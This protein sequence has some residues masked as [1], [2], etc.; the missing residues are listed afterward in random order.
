VNPLTPAL[1][2]AAGTLLLHMWTNG[3]YGYFRDELYFL[4]CGEH[5]AWGYADM[6]PMVALVAHLS[7]AMFG[8]S[9]HAIRFFP[10]VAGAG[11][12]ILT[13]LITRELGGRR[14]AVILACLC[15][16]VAPV[17]LAMDDYLS[18]N[19][20]EPLFWMGGI[21]AMIK[22]IKLDDEKKWI[23]FGVFAG[24]GLMNKHSTAFFGLAVLIAVIL[25]PERRF[26]KN[27]WIWI[28]G[29]IAFLIFLPNLLW[30]IKHHWATLELLRNVQKSGKDVVLSPLAFVGQQ[31][32]IMH[33]LTAPV[34]IAGLYFFLFDREG[35]RFRVLGVTFVVFFALMMLMH[36]KNYYLAPI[37]PMMM[38]GGAV[39]WERWLSSRGFGWA[40][41]VYPALL[42]LGGIVAAPLV[43]PVLS[44]PA[45]LQYEAKL[46]ISTPKTEVA[47][48]GLL[49][50]HFGDRFGWPEMV[51]KVA[52]IYNSLPADERAKTAIFANNYGEAGAI[53]FFGPKYGLPKA[54]SGHQNYWFWGP[55][56]YTGEIAIILQ[57]D[58]ESLEQKYRSVEEVGV[59][60]HPYAMMEERQP[61][62]LCRGRKI[63]FQDDWPKLK[64]W[65]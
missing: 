46:G 15:I 43:L 10:A 33:P 16:L 30:Q 20:F 9:L 32:F 57:G 42:L 12:M 1:F 41:V 61:I 52:K 59:T 51:E 54:I 58:R 56:E 14:F 21:Y 6:A 11:V 64:H 50:Q 40:K 13:G 53:D 22:A 48:R 27:K 31:V 25:T 34:W 55:R 7:R 39:L 17:Y 35:K 49:P 3:G 63:S 19:G 45:F 18:M 24:L 37:Y 44:I 28:A 62:Y 60:D 4:A 23:W 65:N 36:G 29:L 47:H 38:A 26:L 2:F 5:L 8:D